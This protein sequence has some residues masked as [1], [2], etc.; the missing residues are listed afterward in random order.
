[1]ESGVAGMPTAS[2]WATVPGYAAQI[3]SPKAC[4]ALVRDSAAQ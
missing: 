1:V 4:E 2:L 3:P